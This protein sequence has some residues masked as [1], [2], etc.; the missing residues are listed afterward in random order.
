MRNVGGLA[1]AILVALVLAAPAA[2]GSRLVITQRDSGKH[3]TIRRGADVVLRL[4]HRWRWTS[5]RIA[6]KG[7]RLVRH[8]FIRD[9]GYDEWEVKVVGRGIVTITSS[10][11]PA[12]TPCGLAT[13]RFR[14]NVRGS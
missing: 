9:P 2:G 8:Y 10:G 12:C 13:R 6:G 14:I 5:P 4:S 3:F 7:V 1:C 11:T